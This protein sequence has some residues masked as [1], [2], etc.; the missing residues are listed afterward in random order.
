MQ[1][2]G[3]PYLVS[4]THDISDRK[5]AEDS[6]RANRQ[7]L[8]GL[9][10]NNGALIY[11][12]DAGGRY[13]LV[14][15]KWE[16]TTGLVRD[17][18][19]GKTDVE[20]FPGELG[21]RF[22]ASDLAALAKDSTVEQEESLT[23]ATG[24]RWFISIKFP[25]QG[26]GGV[27]SLCVISTDITERKRLESRMEQ[28]ATTDGLTGI[29][30][31]RHFLE[32]AETEVKRVSRRSSP[33]IL[34]LID[35]DHFKHINDT[36]G[37]QAGDQALIL[38]ARVCQRNIRELDHFARFGGDEFVLLLPD[39]TVENAQIVLERIRNDLARETKLFTLSVGV[40]FLH[41][42]DKLEALIERADQT[43]YR[44]KG[45]GRNQLLVEGT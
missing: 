13:E 5:K 19:M 37:H 1:L 4:V 33:L 42:D 39:T 22:H 36:L 30:N 7:F 3:I 6:L 10:E 32:L 28:L 14:N 27:R 40:S 26:M 41:R 25:M 38:L 8:S 35:L 29:T 17:E 44:V 23:D 24:T 45:R 34:A 2:K 31:R 11:V 9:I 15:R 20:L 43:L 18:A 12:K 21:S 16:E